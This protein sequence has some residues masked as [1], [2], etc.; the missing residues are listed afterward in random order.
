M[1]AGNYSSENQILNVFN[2]MK[3]STTLRD[4]QVR[5][6]DILGKDDNPI[7]YLAPIGSFFEGN[8]TLIKDMGRWRADHQYAYPSRFEVTDAGTEKWLK[9]TVIENENR[10]L[11]L[12]QNEAGKSIGHIG[13]LCL[14]GTRV[15]I[16]NV[17]RGESDSPGI[18]SASLAELEKF[19][20]EE[21]G[22]ENLELRVLESNS[23]AVE[24]YLK[25]GY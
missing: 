6:I 24:F 15:E 22:L 11:F 7:G 9:A 8:K 3:A 10:L 17:L 21:L 5:S 2:F 13:L 19:A 1:Q 25:L 20:Y 4:V 18:V 12:I 16:D 23:H 14:D